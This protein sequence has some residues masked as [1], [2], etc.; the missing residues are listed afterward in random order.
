MKKL[1]KALKI[2]G[3]SILILLLLA[4]ITPILFK[5]Q[6]VAKIKTEINKNLN[7]VVD[8]KDVDISLLRR[9]PRLSVRLEDV[10]VIGKDEFAKDTLLSSKSVDAAMNLFSL[11]KEEKNI[12]S[13]DLAFPRIHALVNKEGKANWDVAKA[14]SDTSAADTTAS[15][16][17][18]KLNHYS[19]HDAYV[20]YKDETAGMSAEVVGLDH[21]GSGELT[22]DVFTLSTKTSSQGASF[23]YEGIPYLSHTKTSINSDILIDNKT[24]KYSFKNCDLVVN[25]L[26]LNATGF[27]QLQDDST[28]NMD[29]SFKSASTDFKDV[30]SLIPAIYKTD[31][32]KLK[33]SGKAD[34]NGFVKGTYSPVQMPAYDVNLAVSEGYFQYP[35][36]PKPLKNIR[37]N[38]K[39]SN[40]DGIADHAVIDISK[41]HIEIDN[42]P[43]DFNLLYKNPETLQY[44]DAAAKGK[45]DLSQLSK[46]IKLEEG[47]KLA[48]ILWADVFAKGNMNALQNQQG[49]FN[50]GGFLD[51]KNLFYASKDFAQP[52][53]H[54]NMKID[55]VN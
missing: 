7:A 11:F 17:K 29:I 41:G 44:L 15:G 21:E 4:I 9:F 46:F 8:F 26:K 12:Y 23:N 6:I 51:I 53:Q 22:E 49:N 19:I 50:A 27:F 34:F 55:I 5:S 38:L 36:L 18:M 48:G 3:I 47:T 16:F 1:R 25:N 33:T 28:Y 52:I 43:L 40:P 13:I 45:I 24:S 14:S 10:S 39:A 2:T 35:D 42:E 32:D 54:G 30:L 20:L 31:F 37:F